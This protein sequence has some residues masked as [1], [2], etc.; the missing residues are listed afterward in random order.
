MEE[1]GF[2]Y[3]LYSIF[4]HYNVCLLSNMVAYRLSFLLISKIE[5]K[6]DHSVA[7]LVEVD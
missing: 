6:M 2:V 5:M 7:Q 3:C 4:H 1:M